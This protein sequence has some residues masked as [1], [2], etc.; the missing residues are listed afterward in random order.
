MCE[1]RR[2]ERGTTIAEFAVISAVFFMIIFGIIEFGRLLY[3]HNALTDAARRG[4]R[5][6]VLHHETTAD[7]ACVKNIVV[8]G[9]THV[10]PK[11]C[12]PTG[13]ALLNGLTTDNVRV[14][15]EG[16]DDDNNPVTPATDFGMNLGTASVSIENY[17]F[18]LSIPLMH[19]TLTMP[20]YVTTLT[21]ESA[22]EKPNDL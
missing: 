9:E 20:H 22:G 15:Y 17:T 10:D 13:P 18:N 21:A 11:T 12:L 19:R 14:T 8:Y 6:A 2:G 4:A 5:Y 1:N 3:T 16:A 7:E